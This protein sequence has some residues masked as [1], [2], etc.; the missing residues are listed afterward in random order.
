MNP[1]WIEISTPRT[2]RGVLCW[3]LEV[4]GRRVDVD[5]AVPAAAGLHTLRL[6]AE[7]GVG[8]RRGALSIEWSLRVEPG[9]ITR[10]APLAIL[11]FLDGLRG[12]AGLTGHAPA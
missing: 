1:G 11:S 8:S 9:R 5:A 12:G 4:D 6:R 7:G 10:V 2:F 3:Q